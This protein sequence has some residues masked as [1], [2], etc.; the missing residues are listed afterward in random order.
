MLH[1]MKLL[2]LQRSCITIGLGLL[3][4][5][6]T[7]ALET[8]FQAWSNSEAEATDEKNAK[9]AQLGE[10]DRIKSNLR[11]AVLQN[12][13]EMRQAQTDWERAIILRD[14]V[15]SG[16]Q[17]S[18][19]LGKEPI[20]V[21]VENYKAIVSGESHQWCTGMALLY[22]GLLQVF[23]IRSRLVNLA[24][25]EAVNRRHSAKIPDTHSAVE[26]LLDERWV[27]QDPTFNMQWELDGNP[28]GILEL[29]Q[30]F[31]SN[32]HPISTTND[33]KVLPRRSVQDYY[34]PY[35]DLLAHVEISEIEVLDP[36]KAGKFRVVATM[37]PG[38]TWRYAVLSSPLS[39]S[40]GDEIGT[41][42][43]YWDFIKSLPE[44]WETLAAK[45]VSKSPGAKGILVTTD[46]SNSHYQLW[47]SL[48]DLPPGDYQ[49]RVKGAVLNGGINIGVLDT[50]ANKFIAN[51]YYWSGQRDRFA[52]SDMVAKF[53][54]SETKA[55]KII[56]SN[57]SFSEE[58][59]T[60]KV[61]NV[62]IVKERAVSSQ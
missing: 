17:I 42:V 37:P 20:P 50:A 53:T 61:E 43:R 18:P 59:S 23:G 27:V 30:A 2:A 51:G 57:W 24:S 56:L 16:N 19:S 41:R 6:S 13:P 12:V 21:T 29:R 1:C 39:P 11:A 3:L 9:L 40:S 47:S 52:K 44:S 34:I 60:W 35:Q 15:Y 10:V 5:C 4:L 45:K 58:P 14:H 36:Q 38:A 26:V 48:E 46:A 22:M 32:K 62:M 33:R 54:L 8:S 25:G 28:L 55:V 7:I 31:L 49:V